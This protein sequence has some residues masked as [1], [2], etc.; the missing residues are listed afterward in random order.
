MASDRLAAYSFV[1]GPDPLLIAGGEGTHVFTADGRRILDAG[2]GAVVV[3]I[4]HGRPEP[5]EAAAA[6]LH[7]GAYTVPVWA[8][9]TRL[10]LI[11]RL[12]ESWLPAGLTRC[13]LVSGGTESVETALRVARQHH[14]TRGDT[15]RWKVIGRSISYHGASLGTLA[16]ANHDR[17]RAGLEPLLLDL[18]KADAL[19]VERVRKLVEAED[20]SSIAAISPSPSAAPRGP[21]W[22]PLTTTCRH[23]ASS[24]PSTGS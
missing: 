1:P 5:A 24:A 11:E 6:V 10:A 17:R 19:D 22:F 3:N 7:Q 16:V 23:F 2:G 21:P 9:E 12:K 4:G 15:D 14:S 20:P 13:L 8:T 18:P